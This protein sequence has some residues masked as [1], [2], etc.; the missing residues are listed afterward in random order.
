MK[1]ANYFSVDYILGTKESRREEAD[2]KKTKLPVENDKEIKKIQVEAKPEKTDSDNE[3]RIVASEKGI[4]FIFL[5]L[6]PARVGQLR[7]AARPK[8]YST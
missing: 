4:S 7:L 2:I 8:R 5:L 6:D 3:Q 1:S